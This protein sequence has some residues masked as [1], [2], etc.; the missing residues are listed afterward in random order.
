MWPA[1]FEPAARRVSG[2]RSTELSY[3]HLLIST[4]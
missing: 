3:D 1:G 4:W 2:D